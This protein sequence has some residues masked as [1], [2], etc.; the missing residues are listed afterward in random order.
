[1]GGV[2]RCGVHNCG[3]FYH[4]HCVELNSNC[5]VK[6]SDVDEVSEALI[7][8]FVTLFVVHDYCSHVTRLRFDVQE[9]VREHDVTFD[10]KSSRQE[11]IV[12]SRS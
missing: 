12:E 7:F 3:R 5:T 10:V 9:G 11:M 6:S 8:A 2:F 4:R 1:M